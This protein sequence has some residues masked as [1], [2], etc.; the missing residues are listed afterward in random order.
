MIRRYY[1]GF[2]ILGLIAL[3]FIA[4][5]CKKDKTVVVPTLT[6]VVL[7]NVTAT[8]LT[9]GGNISDDGGGPITARGVCWSLLKNPTI[10][11]RDS[12]TVNGT[13]SGVYASAVKGL[14]SGVTYYVRAY[15]TNS[16]GTGYGNELSSKYAVTPALTTSLVVAV[17]DSVVTCGGTITSDGGFD[18]TARGVCWSTTKSPTLTNNITKDSTGVGTF[19]SLISNLSPDVV[20][21][22]RAYATNKIGTA[23]GNERSFTISKLIVKDVDGNLYHFFSVGSQV[24]LAENLK[25]TRFN[26]S[27]SISLVV[28][29]SSWSSSKFVSPGYCWYNSD[30]S[31]YKNPYG[32][33]YNWYAVSTGKLCPTGWHVPS[34]VDWTVL[35]EYLGGLS[36]AGSKMKENTLLY[37][38]NP[39][40]GATN[41]SGFTALPG[42]WRTDFGVY[43]NTGTY[44]YWWSSSSVSNTVAYYRYL[45]YGNGIATRS[46]ISQKYG[47]S[48]RCMKN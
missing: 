6:T 34:D 25:T 30:E 46:F 23:Y 8:A 41:E 7:T 47:L 48:V 14:K 4:T 9:S 24:W 15:A 36:V 17:T 44:G 33:L 18:V 26:D 1:I 27:T 16:A 12:I 43:D 3:M 10:D 37:W 40:Q 28:D 22:I 11:S 38:R 5:G 19:T 45:Y 20:Y 21:Y 2:L 29:N 39:N 32:A 13:G 42:G 31:V 35:T